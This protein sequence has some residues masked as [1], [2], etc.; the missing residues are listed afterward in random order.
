[1]KTIKQDV[2]TELTV[3]KS[4]FISHIFQVNTENE[5]KEKIK[6]INKKYYDAKHNCYAYI[7]DEI[8]EDGV[9]SK[10]EKSSDNGEPSGTAGAPMLDIL[11]KQNI[12]NVVVI[13]TRYFGG[14]LLGTGG[15]VKAYSD[16]VKEALNKIDFC[17]KDIGKK[18]LFKVEYSDLKDFEYNCNKINANILE[19]K[20]N[21]KIDI[22]VEIALNNIT[23]LENI[24]IKYK[25]YEI[26]EENVWI[27]CN[28]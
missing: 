10:I 25:N 4:K 2:S 9:I 19:T 27:E 5:A 6:E 18:L 7:V 14:I 20:Y 16:S 13:V 11:K 22:I 1:M 12:S 3:K 8:N 23:N 28:T 17:E 21:E 15:L 24:D 26:I